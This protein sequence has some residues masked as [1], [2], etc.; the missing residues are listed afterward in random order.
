LVYAVDHSDGKKNKITNLNL[1]TPGGEKKTTGVSRLLGSSVEISLQ[2]EIEE[3]L[4]YIS[5]IN[6]KKKKKSTSKKQIQII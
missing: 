2:R 5:G 1:E 6:I 4:D 3:T